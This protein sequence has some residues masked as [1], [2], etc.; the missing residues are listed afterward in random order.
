MPTQW[1]SGFRHTASPAR[2]TTWMPKS[3]NLDRL[4]VADEGLRAEGE[5]AFVAVAIDVDQSVRAQP[6][7]LVLQG[8]DAV[9]R[10][11]IAGNPERSAPGFDPQARDRFVFALLKLC[12]TVDLHVLGLECGAPGEDGCRQRH[13]Y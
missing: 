4:P 1:P 2:F 8:R 7:R 11:R 6:R 3:R 9:L 5:E 12:R 13:T 10:R